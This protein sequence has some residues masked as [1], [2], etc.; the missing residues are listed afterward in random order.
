MAAD[1]CMAK[2]QFNSRSYMKIR[3]NTIR[4]S[5]KDSALAE[6]VIEISDGSDDLITV[7]DLHILRDKQGALWVA[8]PSYRVPLTGRHGYEYR[9]TVALSH[10]LRRQVKDAVL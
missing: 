10:S 5:R 3:V 4:H 8:M 9:D 1:T 2:P 7:H 6:A